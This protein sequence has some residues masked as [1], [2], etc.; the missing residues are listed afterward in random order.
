MTA[1]EAAVLGVVE[2]V[3]EYL[4]VS[5]TG[6]LILA[7]HLLGLGAGEAEKQ[8]AGAYAICIQGGAILAVLGL[9][10]HRVRQMG[11]GLLGR[12]PGGSRLAQCLLLAFLPAAAF[13]FLFGDCIEKHLFGLWPVVAAW[14]L[15]GL[16]ILA[17]PR[18]HRA[19]KTSGGAALDAITVRQALWIGLAQ[20][21]ALWP[22]TSRSLATILGGI[23]AG[24]GLPAAVEFS[25]LLGVLT[26]GAATAYQ[27]VQHGPLI[28]ATLG[29][30]AP[31]V[32]FL[33]ATVSAA[34]AVR[35]LTCYLQRGGL[36]PFGYYRIL[37]AGATAFALLA[38][39]P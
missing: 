28:L 16:A 11:A 12:D 13:G 22:G 9:Y 21:L 6:H 39:P 37:L 20:C 10:R 29:W 24:L 2:G 15:G 1:L 32:G 36:E 14:F 8:A 38:L 26:L 7:Q 5:S 33:A 3:T 19:R 34:V 17:T 25:F 18:L 4:P 30:F 31:A 35:W 23:L 27:A